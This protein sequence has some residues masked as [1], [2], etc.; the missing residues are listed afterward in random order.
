MKRQLYCSDRSK[1]KEPP[2]APR[3]KRFGDDIVQ[4]FSAPRLGKRL[5]SLG[6]RFQLNCRIAYSCAIG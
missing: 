1:S 4:P 3:K 2:S 6:V 5:Y